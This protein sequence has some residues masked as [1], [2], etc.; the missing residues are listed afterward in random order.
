MARA[1]VEAIVIEW[2]NSLGG[3]WTAYGDKP[4]TAPE[5][6]ILVDRTGGP[7]EAMMLDQAEILIEVYHKTS[8]STAKTKALDLA[9]KVPLPTGMLANDSITRAKVNSVVNLDDTLGQYHRYQVY[10][11]IWCSRTE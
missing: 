7:R 3:G 1:D 9:D 5:Q 4:D 6:Y 10:C 2:L 11:D 8:R